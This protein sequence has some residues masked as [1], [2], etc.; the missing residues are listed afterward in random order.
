MEDFLTMRKPKPVQTQHATPFTL[1]QLQHTLQSLQL[2]PGFLLHVGTLEPRK[3]LLLLLHAYCQLPTTIRQ[4]H[5]LVLVGAH[6]WNSQTIH[7]FIHTHALS[8]HIR[9]LGYLPD[10]YFPALY[11]AAHALLFPTLYEGFGMPTIEMMACGGAVIASNIPP[12]AETVGTHAH[13]LD[14]HDTDAWRNAMLRVCT[15]RDWWQSLRNGVQSVAQRFTWTHCAQ[16]TLH[17]Y[18]I[19]LGIDTNLDQ[20]SRRCA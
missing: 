13:L 17:A 4:Q 14:P 10:H 5:P 15:D 12:I 20:H 8:H 11:S 6:G 7:H 16:Q 19:T 2:Q 18:R 9:W 3:N 1:P